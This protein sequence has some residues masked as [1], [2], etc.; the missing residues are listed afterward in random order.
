MA[1]ASPPLD[2]AMT[3]DPP[4]LFTLARVLAV[5]AGLD[6]TP[7]DGIVQLGGYTYVPT[8]SADLTPVTR[9]A[10]TYTYECT[11]TPGYFVI[12][13]G[14]VDRGFDLPKF[15]DKAFTQLRADVQL[16]AGLTIGVS[17]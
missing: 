13:A 5:E 4:T 8:T 15:V 7:L 10:N 14:T 16:S 1:T 11:Y 9:R 17:D 3:S 2:F 6:P 12:D